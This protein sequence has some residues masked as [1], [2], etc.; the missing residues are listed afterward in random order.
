MLLSFQESTLD[1]SGFKPVLGFGGAPNMP[2]ER[3]LKGTARQ[4]HRN[5]Q[6][7][8]WSA[9]GKKPLLGSVWAHSHQAPA[10]GHPREENGTQRVVNELPYSLP[11]P[12]VRRWSCCSFLDSSFLWGLG[13]D[14]HGAQMPGSLGQALDWPGPGW[15]AVSRT[16]PHPQA[17]GLRRAGALSAAPTP[18]LA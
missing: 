10:Q 8:L 7:S 16:P 11:T 1:R 14:P 17:Q 12:G 9:S 5:R 6:P 2:Q 15:A 3:V 18:L 4:V 13:G